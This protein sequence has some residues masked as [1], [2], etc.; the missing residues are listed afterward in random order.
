MS[1]FNIWAF[2]SDE[3]MSNKAVGNES[4]GMGSGFYVLAGVPF[5][6]LDTGGTAQVILSALILHGQVA[7]CLTAG[8]DRAHSDRVSRLC[9]A[10]AKSK[11]AT[12]YERTQK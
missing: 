1:L 12:P 11:G 3:S 7:L 4:S 5:E 2:F 8:H 10:D 9:L 6:H